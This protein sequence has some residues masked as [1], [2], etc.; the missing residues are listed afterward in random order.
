MVLAD[1]AP[2]RQ[3]EF[4]GGRAGCQTDKVN[5]RGLQKKVREA[6]A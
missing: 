5:G 4:R 1:A 3:E 2:R 6:N